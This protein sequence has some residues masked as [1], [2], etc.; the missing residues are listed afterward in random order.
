MN[1][2]HPERL[3]TASALAMGTCI[4]VLWVLQRGKRKDSKC[5]LDEILR[6]LHTAEASIPFDESSPIHHS[7]NRGE[8][9]SS[10]LLVLEYHKPDDFESLDVRLFQRDVA[11]GCIDPDVFGSDAGRDWATVAAC[12]DGGWRELKL[13]AF[14]AHL[15]TP[16]ALFAPEIDEATIAPL[17]H[18]GTFT[19]SL[20]WDS[21][22]LVSEL[23]LASA[24]WR[25]RVRGSTVVEL[26][27][28]L[29][30]PGWVA[31]LL[32]AR[33]ALL[34]DRGAIS[35][36]V[37]AARAWNGSPPSVAAVEFPWSDDGAKALLSHAHL[38]GTRPDVLLACDCIF[39]PLFGGP[40]LLLEMLTA[41]AG[42][43]TAILVALERRPDD[44][45]EDFFAQASA[46][47]FA[48]KVL[49]QRGRVVCLQMRYGAD[50]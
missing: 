37:E 50:F 24:E 3:L 4:A 16:A 12:V 23:L 21:A 32:G 22:I 31:H 10:E 36:L 1:L 47:G 9:Y 17:Y 8:R 13:P 7:M 40:F 26:G 2:Q 15:A 42:P 49:F 38:N 6:T 27:C 28:G 39:T 18:D 43:H 30:L 11:K 45:A 29:G 33:A 46:A 41:L 34:T 48:T 35:D 25:D 14:L 5:T 44:G 19:G 20:L